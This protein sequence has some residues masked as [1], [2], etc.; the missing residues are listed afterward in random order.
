MKILILHNQLWTQYKSV[1]FQGI[2]DSFSSTGDEL[3]VLQ[4]SICEQSRLNIID[5]DVAN[6]E[7]TYPFVLLNHTSLEEASALRTTYYW[8]KYIITFKPD[9]INLTGYA[10]PG[11]LLILLFAKIVGIKTIMTNESIYSQRLHAKSIKQ[12]VID[13][14]KGLILRCTDGFLSYGIKSN[15]YLYRFGISKNRIYSFLNAFDRSKFNVNEVD[16]NHS[17]ENQNYLLFIGRLSEEKNL[18]SLI[19]LARRFKAHKFSCTIQIVGDGPEYNSLHDIINEESLPVQLLG[20]KNWNQLN[21]IYK[22]ALAF[23]LPSL[24]ET[25]GMVANEALEMGI[26]VICSDVCGCADDLVINELNGL[27]LND[28]DFSVESKDDTYMYLRHYLTRLMEQGTR[29]EIN[30]KISSIYEEKRLI[31]EF[32]EAFKA[33]KSN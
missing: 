2:H 4:T 33:I 1:V 23:I 29:I 17:Q 16:H 26:P 24:N 9:V 30:Q 20:A 13:L 19:D 5:F 25:W 28:F 3:L 6:F 32:I 7:Y 8:F 31:S 22:S 27:V 15:D 21:V 10:D 14:Y 18:S 12:Y 11:T